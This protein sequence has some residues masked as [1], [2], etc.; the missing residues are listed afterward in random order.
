[1]IDTS[2]SYDSTTVAQRLRTSIP[3]ADVERITIQSD[4]CVQ[5]EFTTA[6]TQETAREQLRDAIHPLGG[7][8]VLAAGS[9]S[10]LRYTLL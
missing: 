1:M 8:I 10:P 9:F 7:D 2:P 4:G 5:V 6:V 3:E